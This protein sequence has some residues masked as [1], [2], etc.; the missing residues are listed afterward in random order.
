MDRLCPFFCVGW[1]NEKSPLSRDTTPMHG[2]MPFDNY[3]AAQSRLFDGLKPEQ[4]DSAVS[5][6][7][8]EACTFFQA[9]WMALLE[10]STHTHELSCFQVFPSSD[11]AFVSE[12]IADHIAQPRQYVRLAGGDALIITR[13]GRCFFPESADMPSRLTAGSCLCVPSLIALEAVWVLALRL[14]SDTLQQDALMQRLQL[15]GRLVTEV[16]ER[17][18]MQRDLADSRNREL[19]LQESD[20]K[21]R[22][23]VESIP[24]LLCYVDRRGRYRLLNSHYARTLGRNVDEVIGRTVSEVMGQS[25][26]ASFRG[27]HSAVLAGERVEYQATVNDGPDGP[28]HF[29]GL[30]VPDVSPD[31]EVVGYY[32]ML[33]DVTRIKA[34]NDESR[35]LRDR[36]AHLDRVVSMHIMASSIAHE[37]KQP[38]SAI[39]S[40]AQAGLQTLTGRSWEIEAIREIL[41]DIEADDRRAT[42]I[43][44]RLRTLV[45]NDDFTGRKLLRLTEIIPEVIQMIRSEFIS[46]KAAVTTEIPS[47]LPRVSADRVQIQQVLV[48]ILLNSLDAVAS[49]PPSER[50]ITVSAWHEPARVCFSVT[51]SGLGIAPKEIESVFKPFYTSKRKGMG[52]GLAICRYIVEDHGGSI[53]AEIPGQRGFRSTVCLPAADK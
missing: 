32:Q 37:V 41:R 52:L 49:C 46:R 6:T 10:L 42:E 45:Q 22:L 2:R 40:N 28:R 39:L 24:G 30:L 27:K 8:Q 4:I 3:L 25:T 5:S 16:I 50:H 20:R 33:Q 51:D 34:L 7:L 26:F 11:K 53:W 48:N 13:G 21:W 35:Q 15:F 47:W 18:R 44:D 9:H 23:M 29:A 19:A 38:L 1:L 43:I 12:L 17:Q 14:A 36:L 31:G